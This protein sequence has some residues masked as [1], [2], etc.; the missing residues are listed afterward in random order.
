MGSSRQLDKFI[1][2]SWGLHLLVEF[3]LS[4]LDATK[5]NF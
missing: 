4:R 1:Y 5:L 2:R 3:P